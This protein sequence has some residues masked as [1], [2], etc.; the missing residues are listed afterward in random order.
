MRNRVKD[1]VKDRVKDKVKDRVTDKVKD[2]IKDK[3][4][5]R[6]KD[7]FSV[8]PSQH[9]YRLVSACLA[10]VTPLAKIVARVKDPTSCPP[11][12]NR[13]NINSLIF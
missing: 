7:H 10:F 4:K 9:L 12:D 5:D 8:L 13:N 3:V 6:V 11:F 2:R 1:K